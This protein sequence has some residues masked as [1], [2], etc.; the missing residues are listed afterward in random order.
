MFN[1]N[2]N[3][4]LNYSAKKS[5]NIM[6][7]MKDINHKLNLSSFIP[8]KKNK[9][10]ILNASNNKD[11]LV[12]IE[13]VS[14]HINDINNIN[15][16]INDI[17]EIKPKKI[18][19]K[20]KYSKSFEK[21]NF[22]LKLGND[23]FDKDVN[24]NNITGIFY[25]IIND[26]KI[27]YGF[28]YEKKN[29]AKKITDFSMEEPDKEETINFDIKNKEIQNNNI[30]NSKDDKKEN[31]NELNEI[32]IENKLNYINNNYFEGINN[33]NNDH[34]EI[35][36][37]EI[38]NKSINQNQDNNI[39]IINSIIQTET[40]TEKENLGINTIITNKEKEQN[41]IN[42][43]E[44]AKNILEG[45]IEEEDDMNESENKKINDT[46]SIFSN[47]ILPPTY[48]PMDIMSNNII[49]V[50]SKYENSNFND[51]MS[52][53]G[54]L[55]HHNFNT[56]INE[57]EIEIMNENAK[58]LDSFIKTPR[59]SGVYNKRTEYKNTNYNM[60]S[61]YNFK[62]MNL[63]MKKIRDK[64]NSYNKDI[65]K[66]KNKINKIDEQIK[67]Y[68]E[69]NKTYEKWIEKEEEESEYLVNMLN[70]KFLNNK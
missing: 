20:I 24:I 22:N 12:N 15:I 26:S 46:K 56:N 18:L 49:S 1:N 45:E 3:L 38:K 68:E 57:A 7:S 34:K 62:N 9:N 16:N 5:K 19:Y 13:E 43:E 52:N 30:I 11:D 59:A 14:N 55:I 2:F 53:K 32:E 64:I 50:N 23:Y 54:N 39:I 40:K 29:L 58:E 31:K 51:I 33:N 70:F 42:K 61:T 48:P 67:N 21:K 8:D 69:C 17:N 35:Q 36:E 60:N 25:N 6:N 66:Y 41:D 63:N 37:E 28:K 10:I 65:E 47:F 27:K 4:N 44:Q